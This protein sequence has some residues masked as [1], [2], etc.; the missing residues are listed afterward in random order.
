VKSTLGIIA[1]RIA[2]RPLQQA[3][4]HVDPEVLQ[5]PELLPPLR[6]RKRIGASVVDV[7]ISDRTDFV[8]SMS[9][10]KLY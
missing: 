9:K 2:G 4:A 6:D 7:S 3:G 5:W 10:Q 1:N 8:I